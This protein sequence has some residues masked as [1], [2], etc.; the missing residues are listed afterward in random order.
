M[1]KPSQTFIINKQHKKDF[2]FAWLEYQLIL[3]V[4]LKNEDYKYYS[5]ISFE[6]C[7]FKE[8]K[9]KKIM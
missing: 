8:K 7:M 6:E 2:V 3:F 9:V 1:V 5:Q 4:K